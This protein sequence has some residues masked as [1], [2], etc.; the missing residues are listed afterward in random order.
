MSEARADSARG[1]TVRKA[2]WRTRF[3]KMRDQVSYL[4]LRALRSSSCRVRQKRAG[5]AEVRGGASV[6]AAVT[7]GAL[8]GMIVSRPK[9]AMRDGGGIDWLGSLDGL[10]GPVGDR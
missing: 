5:A 9:A 6:S 2:S 8:R 3:E 1:P 7:S 10:R 4:H